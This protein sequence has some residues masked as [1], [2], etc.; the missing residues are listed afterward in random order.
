MFLAILLKNEQVRKVI[1]ADMCVNLNR[2][3]FKSHLTYQI[4]D[5]GIKDV[6]V[7]NSFG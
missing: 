3:S 2:D 6:Y 1:N 5:S 7:L 4:K